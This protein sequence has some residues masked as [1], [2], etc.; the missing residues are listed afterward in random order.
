MPRATPETLGQMA[1][2][3]RQTLDA[4][5]TEAHDGNPDRDYTAWRK[6]RDEDERRLRQALA[7]M[8]IA[9]S[10]AN[11]HQTRV[12]FGGVSSTSTSGLWGA[13]RNW[14]VAAE[15]KAAVDA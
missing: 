2:Q 10:D 6:A 4:M 15:R 7:A 8:G 5:P 11:V 3:L 13:C 14:I 9:V 12:T 1:A